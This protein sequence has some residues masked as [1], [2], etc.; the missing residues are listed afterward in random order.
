MYYGVNPPPPPTPRPKS[1]A[2]SPAYDRRKKKHE[3][4]VADKEKLHSLEMTVAKQQH[5]KA[6]T[7][8]KQ[9]HE[10]AVADMQ[11]QHEKALLDMQ[12]AHEKA[13]QASELKHAEIL[14]G[15]RLDLS[16]FKMANDQFADVHKTQQKEMAK[17]V[18][19]GLKQDE[20]L[21]DSNRMLRVAKQKLE[22]GDFQIT[23]KI[24][25]FSP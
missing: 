19:E 25:Q 5:E 18:A 20:N 22:D 13:T 23:M 16:K 11:H 7:D 2:R 21:K 10:K 6:L 1:S 17:L 14:A 24:Q 9:E 3:S 12:Q 8:L 15:V 4:E